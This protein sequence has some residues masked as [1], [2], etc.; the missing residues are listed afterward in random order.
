MLERQ[1]FAA[2]K[3]LLNSVSL[4]IVD[5]GLPNQTFY[6]AFKDDKL[7]GCVGFEQYGT[8]GLFRSLAVIS[9][10]KGKGIGKA[11][12]DKIADH[13]LHAG[14]KQL[15]LLTTT[16]DIFFEKNGWKKIERTAVNNVINNTQEFNNICPSTATCMTFQVFKNNTDFSVQIF[17]SGFNCSQSVFVPVAINLGIPAAQAFQ[18]ATGFGAGMV[19]RGE[20]C[21]AITGAMM[22]LGLKYGRSKA[23]DTQAR[24]KTYALINQLYTRFKEKHGSIICKELLKTDI[25][26]P[27]NREKAFK[28][29]LFDTLCPKLVEDAA[30]ILEEL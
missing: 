18:I 24:D 5:V 15:Y 16:A 7:V 23:K 6:G 10:L 14:I 19:Y 17:N 12:H 27:E 11:L 30:T 8:E 21:G 13:C 22:A 1:E 2:M 25:S 9:E 20:T 3:Q 29:G 4:P 28:N 26:I